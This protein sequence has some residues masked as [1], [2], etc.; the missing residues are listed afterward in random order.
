VHL[1]LIRR[2]SPVPS[3]VMCRVVSLLRSPPPSCRAL[4]R[5]NQVVFRLV[6]ISLCLVVSLLHNPLS[7]RLRSHRHP[8]ALSHL[9][10]L[11]LSRARSRQ[12]TGQ[13]SIHSSG[14]PSTA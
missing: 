9:E 12:S 13:S 8:Q 10:N 7:N 11:P 5:I 4:R 3:P 6:S 14:Q 1:R 2:Y